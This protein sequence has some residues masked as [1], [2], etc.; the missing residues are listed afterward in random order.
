LITVV[1][2]SGSVPA[3]GAATATTPGCPPGLE[4]TA[5][6]F[7]FGGSQ[8]GLFADGSLNLDGTWSATGFGYFGPASDL[9][10]Y[11]YCLPVSG[12]A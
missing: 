2:A 7:S 1:S 11:G 4:L 12:A 10:A 9:T 6:G 8:D 5:G 3:G